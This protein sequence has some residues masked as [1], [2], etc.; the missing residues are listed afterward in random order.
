MGGGAVGEAAGVKSVKSCRPEHGGGGRII[1]D[2]LNTRA[3][4]AGNTNSCYSIQQ[5]LKVFTAL[6][7]GR[8]WALKTG[9]ANGR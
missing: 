3:E 1:Q 2:R 9:L 5:D 8:S 4:P 6:S 7:R